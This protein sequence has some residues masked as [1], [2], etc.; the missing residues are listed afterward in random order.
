MTSQGSQWLATAY[1]RDGSQATSG[2]TFTDSYQNEVWTIAREDG[3]EVPVFTAE[4][5]KGPVPPLQE[6]E[7]M[8]REALAD[9]LSAIG[10]NDEVGWL[11]GNI[12]GA[13]LLAMAEFQSWEGVEWAVESGENDVALAWAE[14]SDGRTPFAWLRGRGVH[15]DVVI[16]TYQDD[17]V[18]GLSFRWCGN[19]VLPT[20]DEGLLRSRRGIPLAGWI[21]KVE[22]VFDTLVDGGSAPGLVS[23]VVLH[24]DTSSTLLIAAE[25]YSRGEWH[26]YDESVV[27]VPDAA[28][29]D[30]L[31]WVPPR[32]KWSSTVV[33]GH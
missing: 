7:V 30:L 4:R 10:V 25:A 3:G 11:T 24:G 13:L 28:T 5:G 1:T 9:L 16:D 31:D 22:V 21:N 29:A 2:W 14:P 6:L 8:T 18:F 27:V 23:E 26:L 15:R 19:R 17:G 12:A 20:S 33:A 32:R